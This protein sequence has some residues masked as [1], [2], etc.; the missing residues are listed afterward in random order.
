[1]SGLGVQDRLFV[2]GNGRS[3]PTAFAPDAGL[4]EPAAQ[5]AG[6]IGA[7]SYP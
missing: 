1:V 5:V 2:S 3:P 6:I 7:D 4:L